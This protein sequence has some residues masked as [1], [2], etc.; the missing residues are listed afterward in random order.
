MSSFC[1]ADLLAYGTSRKW[2]DMRDESGSVFVPAAWA[3]RLEAVV[4]IPAV[5]IMTDRIMA[6]KRGTWII[7]FFMARTGI[8][9]GSVAIFLP[10]IQSVIA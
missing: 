8:L 5:I 7:F 10:V 1:A 9:L 3:K 2:A 4:N 6:P